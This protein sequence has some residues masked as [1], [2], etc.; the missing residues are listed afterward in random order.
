MTTLNSLDIG[1]LCIRA[2][3]IT[4][5]AHQGL[6]LFLKCDASKY[7]VFDDSPIFGENHFRNI[8]YPKRI[9]IKRIVL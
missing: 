5:F 8:P 6:S 1:E 2:E 3:N 7:R 9:D 4:L